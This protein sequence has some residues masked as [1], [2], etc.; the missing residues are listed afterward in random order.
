MGQIRKRG[1][2][3]WI[4]YYRNGRRFEEKA[5]DARTP[6]NEALTVAL[7]IG[8]GFGRSWADSGDEMLREFANSGR[9]GGARED[10]KTSTPGS[11]PGGAR[12]RRIALRRIH[13]SRVLAAS[14]SGGEGLTPSPHSRQT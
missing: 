11:N 10:C 1:G 5:R 7:T 13:R 4:R 9:I 14:D 3:W 6:G 12:N 2:V 8:S